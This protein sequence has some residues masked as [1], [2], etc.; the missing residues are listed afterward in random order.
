MTEVNLL[1]LKAKDYFNKIE[2]CLDIIQR[3]SK[4]QLILRQSHLSQ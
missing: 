2:Y 4:N 1:R 3:I